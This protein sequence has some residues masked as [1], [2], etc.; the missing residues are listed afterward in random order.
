MTD[1]GLVVTPDG[2]VLAETTWDRSQ[3]DSAVARAGR[4]AP[5]A[6]VPGTAASLISLWSNNFHHW[7]LDALPRYGVLERAGRANLPL[8]VPRRLTHFQR[9][10]LAL[11]GI[12]SSSLVPY[13]G[14]HV[15]P[16]ILVWP[17]GAA[18]IGNPTPTVVEW[19]R[20]RLGPR[21]HDPFRRLYVTRAHVEATELRRRIVNEVELVKLLIDRGFEVV[22]PEL[23]SL[24]QQAKL[25]AEA[26]IV[27]GAHG[28]AHT[29]TL[30]SRRSVLIEIF[31]PS[32]FNNCNLMLSRA[33]GHDYWYVTGKASGPGDI[34]APLELVEATLDCALPT[35]RRSP[36]SSPS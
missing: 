10:S 7:L 18:H 9:E 14:S 5:P 19:L 35:T 28:A 8:V 15:A 20:E 34:I 17:S 2:R 31:E 26:E 3:L 33:S 36:R 32:F 22:R 6:R 25:F 11:L 27:V 23:L 16:D 24:A 12:Q 21:G 1:A 4:L 30:F 29:N 13:R